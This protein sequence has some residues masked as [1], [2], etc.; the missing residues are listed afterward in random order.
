M[1]TDAA[2]RAALRRLAEATQ[3]CDDDICTRNR[4][5]AEEGLPSIDVLDVCQGTSRVPLYRDAQGVALFRKACRQ[6]HSILESTVTAASIRNAVCAE[7]GCLGWVPL[8]LSEVHLETVALA[9]GWNDLPNMV[10]ENYAGT[11][12]L[13]RDHEKAMLAALLALDATRE[14]KL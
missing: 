3:I 7:T 12:H 1:T 14:A 13:T 8:E 6:Y 11:M 10:M 5:A 2:L 4:K 9:K